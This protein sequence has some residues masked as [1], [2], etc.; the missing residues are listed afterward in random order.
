MRPSS[1]PFLSE[2]PAKP[3]VWIN[4][5]ALGGRDRGLHFCLKEKFLSLFG[6]SVPWGKSTQIEEV[7]KQLT[8]SAS[9]L[10]VSGPLPS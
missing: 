10:I 7:Q 6:D 8:H 1:R 9:W 2:E 3:P 5:G 4:R